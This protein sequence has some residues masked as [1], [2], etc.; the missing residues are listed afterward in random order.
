MQ[1]NTLQQ[2]TVNGSG[3][4]AGLTVGVIS[5]T[6]VNTTISGSHILNVNSGSFQMQVSLDEAGWYT[7]QVTN[8]DTGRS[9]SYPFPASDA[10][11]Y[12]PH[13]VGGIQIVSG[14]FTSGSDD[15]STPAQG[16]G[17]VGTLGCFATTNDA[18]PKVFAITCE[19]VVGSPILGK[20]TQ[21]IGTATK[22]TIS[23][24]GTNTPNSLIEIEFSVG[25]NTYNVFYLTSGTETPGDIASKI[26]GLITALAINGVG[27]T[28]DTTAG[29][30][31]VTSSASSFD[32]LSCFVYGSA[33]PDPKASIRASVTGTAISLS[34]VASKACG[35]Y[36]TIN[37]GGL[38]PTLG[39]FVAI[40][41]KADATTVATSVASAITNAAAIPANRLTG[42]TA[43]AT[44]TTVNLA[45]V[46]SVQ[47]D[48]TRDIRVGQPTN[49]FCSRCCSCCGDRIGVVFDAR[50]DLD[51]ALIQ[52][53]PGLKYRAEIPLIGVVKGALTDTEL[54]QKPTGY[55]LQKRGRS[56]GLTKGTL[57]ALDQTGIIADQDDQNP[58]RWRLFDRAYDG[59]F[60]IKWGLNPFGIH[61]D[62]GAAVMTATAAS[63]ND[64][65]KVVGIL[66]G[67]SSNHTVAT[68]IT[69]IITAY[70]A[71][72]LSIAT[73][74][75]TGQDLVVPPYPAKAAPAVQ[76]G[77]SASNVVAPE[78]IT[79]KLRQVER[80]ISATPG[81]RRYG[82]LVRRHFAEAQ[83]LVAA[84]RRVATV[85]HRNG[86]PQIAS[87]LLRMAC[88]PEARLPSEFEGKPLEDCLKQIQIVFAKYGSPQLS[89]DLDRHAAE[90]IHL[91]HL[92][93]S[94]VLSI[95]RESAPA[96]ATENWHG[97]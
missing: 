54:K 79:L 96:P 63:D 21:L 33:V 89:A 59:A 24:S 40:A 19:H 73:A 50:V 39:V 75:A 23:F 32:F 52:L 11:D 91:T 16:V 66:F 6:A 2:F 46:E 53:D 44:G 64:Y 81:G 95:L 27:A 31:T 87:G 55:A 17:A 20:A 13:F 61:G 4:Q 56:T 97:G 34:G 26:T 77:A 42:V 37:L 83:T 30:V 86:G 49:S 7:I 9:N 62:S 90:I 68:P 15:G 94:E 5:P 67:H 69:P 72:N 74:T 10:G 78:P 18:N 47:C 84:N 57:L 3:L 70:S 80:E 12:S 58:P 36:V 45:N 38:T 88:F 25:G 22:P 41:A 92:P 1:Q 51:V 82:E 76:S 29:T 71:Y 28:A 60:S 35:A 48:I 14:G 85:W 8:P 93:Y 65:N 43:S